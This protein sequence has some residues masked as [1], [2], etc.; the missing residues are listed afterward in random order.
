MPGRLHAARAA[1]ARLRHS[2]PPVLGGLPMPSRLLALFNLRPGIAAAEYEHWARTVDL[3]TVNALPSIDKF[4]VFRVTGKL[5]SADAAPYAYAEII[6]I[7]NMESFGKDVATEQMRAVAA[8]FGRLAETLFL[9]T[10]PLD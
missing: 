3:P 10:E 5:G 2:Q 6:E 8:E 1:R 7:N 4:E 9:T